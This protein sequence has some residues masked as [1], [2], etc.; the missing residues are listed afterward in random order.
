MGA[1]LGKEFD[2]FTAS[3]LAR[4][5]SKQAIAALHAAQQRH[6]VW[7]KANDGRCAFIH[8]K[9]R[10]TLLDHL[11][12]HERRELHRRAAV[13]LEAEAPDRVYDLAYHFDAAGESQ[14][15]LP[16]ALAAAE[17]VRTQY[18]LELCWSRADIVWW[19]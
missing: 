11:P 8:D 5:T 4:Q 2:L 19:W 3:K 17:Q 12:E 15:A 6:I 9:L 16:Y 7:A 14:H 1:V 13:D 10:Q 18:A